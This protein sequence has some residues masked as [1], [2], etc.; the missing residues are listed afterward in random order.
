MSERG[1]PGMG[2]LQKQQLFVR[3]LGQLI[4]FVYTHP[5]WALTLGE[6]FVGQTDGADG[7]HDG[8]HA[9]SGA[10]YTK[11]GIDLNLFVENVYVRGH[12][13]AWDEIGATWLGLHPLCRWG[14]TFLSRDYNHLSI[15][16]E[17]RA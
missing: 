17:G 15:Y 11:L 9:A 6:G 13:P 14:G 4:G 8:P 1:I 16:H 7:D 2:L 10:H 3:L 12:H 5:T